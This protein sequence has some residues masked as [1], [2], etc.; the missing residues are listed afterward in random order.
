M[1]RLLAVAALGLLAACAVDTRGLISQSHFHSV[2]PNTLRVELIDMTDFTVRSTGDQGIRGGAR[3]GELQDIIVSI[4]APNE[5]SS[6][7]GRN[8]TGL[9]NRTRAETDSLSFV[10]IVVGD[11]VAWGRAATY[12]NDAVWV[13]A[14]PDSR[15]SLLVQAR[16]LDCTGERVCGRHNDGA[17]RFDF[18]L[19]SL[20]ARLEPNCVPEQIFVWNEAGGRPG[21]RGARDVAV[22]TTG[23]PI[24]VPANG[25]I[26]IRPVPR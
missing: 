26:C 2:G 6:A 10:T 23:A 7:S 4:S 18:M 22:T 16:D 21:F 19:P 17:F 20:P 3:D 25:A 15:I 9:V 8:A 13:L 11:R 5:F 24:I 1:M 12:D 14:E